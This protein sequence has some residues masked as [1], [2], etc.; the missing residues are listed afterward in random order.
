[1]KGGLIP[2]CC[3]AE[4]SG[5]ISGLSGVCPVACECVA[6]GAIK[7]VLLPFHCVEL[8]RGFYLVSGARLV[9]CGCTLVS[10]CSFLGWS[11]SLREEDQWSLGYELGGQECFVLG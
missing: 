7:G 8:C 2:S 3:S 5:V 6:F 9:L 11:M 1:M 10:F 4:G